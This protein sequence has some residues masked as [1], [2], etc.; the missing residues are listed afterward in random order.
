MHFFDQPP[1]SNP[2]F[3][4]IRRGG[5]LTIP[6]PDSVE[7]GLNKYKWADLCINR[8]WHA[9]AVLPTFMPMKH[10]SRRIYT[11]KGHVFV[12][13][14]NELEALGY[15]RNWWKLGIDWERTGDCVIFY[16]R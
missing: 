10:N 8:K 9:I 3:V 15:H 2:K 5:F 1:R 13:A 4:S 16:P 12:S 11:L 7:S 6:A 14:I